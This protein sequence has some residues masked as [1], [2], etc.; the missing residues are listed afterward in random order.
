MFLLLENQPKPTFD[1]LVVN[2]LNGNFTVEI[3]GLVTGIGI[4]VMIPIVLFL[5]ETSDNNIINCS[6]KK[7]QYK[8]N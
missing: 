2:F 4:G 1:D 6:L 5:L 8:P 3:L 7:Y